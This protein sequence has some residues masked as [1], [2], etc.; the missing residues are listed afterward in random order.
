[1]HSM[2]FGNKVMTQEQKFIS[3]IKSTSCCCYYNYYCYNILLLLLLLKYQKR[4]HIYHDIHNCDIIV[5]NL[6]ISL[7]VCVTLRNV[8]ETN[9]MKRTDRRQ[10]PRNSALQKIFHKH[11]CQSPGL[12]KLLFVRCAHLMMITISME[13]L[14]LITIF[15]FPWID[16]SLFVMLSTEPWT[17]SSREISGYC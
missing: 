9:A 4:C 14:I 12:L 10:D 15:Q 13:I 16:R 11:C 7:Y 1:M 5:T 6:S 2:R 3:P 8:N 17:R